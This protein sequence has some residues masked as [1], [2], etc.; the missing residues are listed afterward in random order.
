MI[1]ADKSQ[2]NP[3]IK[4]IAIKNVIAYNLGKLKTRSFSY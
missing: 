4:I 1:D 3:V 2:I